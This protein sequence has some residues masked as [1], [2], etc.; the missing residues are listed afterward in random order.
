MFTV[1]SRFLYHRHRHHAHPYF[2]DGEEGLGARAEGGAGGDDVVDEEDVLAGQGVGGR[3][4]KDF[5]HVEPTV[6]DLFVGLRVGVVGAA[7]AGGVDGELQHAVEAAGYPF[8]LVVAAFTLFTGMEGDGQEQVGLVGQEG[9]AIGQSCHATQPETDFLVVVIFQGMDQLLH[10][11]ALLVA[12]EGDGM[13]DV[14]L[15]GKEVG[16]RVLLQVVVAGKRQVVEA[17]QADML[18]AAHQRVVA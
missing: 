9:V 13:E 5:L 12:Q 16:G 1:F 10:V 15:A 3:D 4:G 2:G 8:R 14:G 7:Q 18:F 17:F 6:V 11:S